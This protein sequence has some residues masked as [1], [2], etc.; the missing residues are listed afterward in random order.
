MNYIVI[1]PHFPSNFSQFCVRLAAQGV[2]VLGI[3]SEVYGNLSQELKSSLTEYYKVDRLENYEQVFKAVAYFTHKYGKI[4]R[5]E[6]HNEHWLE[7][8]AKLR[9]DF[10]VFGYKPDDL[11]VV[12][13]KSKMKDV[14]MKQKVPVAPGILVTSLKQAQTFV[15]KVG[16][17]VVAKPDRGVGASHTYKIADKAQLEAFFDVKPAIDYVMEAFVE[18]EIHT[19]DGLTDTQGQIVYTNSFIFPIGVMETVNED[20]DMTYYAQKRIPEDLDAYGR[21]IVEAF[22]LKERFFHIEF[23]RC[24]D[25]RLVVLEINVRPP[26]GYSMDIFNFANDLNFFDEYAKIVSGKTVE[27]RFGNKH[28]CLYV[29]QKSVYENA[30]LLSKDEVMKRYGAFMVFNGPIA[31]IFSKAIGNYAYILKGDEL[32]PLRSMAAAILEKKAG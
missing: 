22:K 28:H 5:I 25:G 11:L 26:G 9:L 3:D 12:Q 1:S 15:K 4:D 16:Y 20:L 17:P 31:S 2:R 7:L 27:H 8:D 6:S 21:R 24:A 14:F 30:Y 32:D 19:F 10:N 13:S 18:G 23:F 29:G